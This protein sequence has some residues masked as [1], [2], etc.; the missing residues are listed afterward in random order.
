MLLYIIRHAWAE[1]PGDPAWPDDYQRP[2]TAEGRKRFRSLVR[3]ISER[4]FAPERLATS[5]FVRCR[6]TAEIIRAEVKGNPELTDLDA[7]AP[8]SDFD[9]LVHWTA[10]ETARAQSIA[11]VGHAPDVG[12]LAALLISGHA[13]PQIHFSKGAVAAIEFSGKDGPA[14]GASGTLLWLVT[15]K[16]LGL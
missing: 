13:P 9:Q 15:A 2:L 10:R 4:G 11:W 7:L 14:R 16:V 8:G 1:E 3:A 6:Q 5:P 12:H